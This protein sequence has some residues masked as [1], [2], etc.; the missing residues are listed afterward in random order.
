MFF[1]AP[2]WSGHEQTSELYFFI[3]KATRWVYLDQPPPSPNEAVSSQSE[4]KQPIDYGAE[5]RKDLEKNKKN[6]LAVSNLDFLVLSSHHHGVEKKK[7][8][9]TF[10]LCHGKADS[11][12][13][14][15][16]QCDLTQVPTTVERRG[17]WEE[18]GERHDCR[19]RISANTASNL[20]EKSWSSRAWER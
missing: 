13:E 11:G 20:L 9:Q 2:P 18:R 17:E 15:K 8:K 1:P 6:T 14:N 7:N 3:P 19:L 10:S 5:K 12:G 16:K 4:C